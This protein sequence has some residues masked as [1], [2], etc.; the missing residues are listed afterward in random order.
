MLTQ[1][2]YKL[3][4]IAGVARLLQPTH[5]TKLTYVAGLW[6]ED[7]VNGL[8]SRRAS[9]GDTAKRHHNTGKG[10]KLP[11]MLLLLGASRMDPLNGILIVSVLWTITKQESQKLESH[12]LARILWDISTADI[13]GYEVLRCGDTT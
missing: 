2:G 4:A 3:P 6:L 9:Y 10:C 8:T 12:L 11:S 5:N 7:L 1:S 13:S